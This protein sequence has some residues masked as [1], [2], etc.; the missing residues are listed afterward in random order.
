M[1]DIINLLI[2]LFAQLTLRECLLIIWMYFVNITLIGHYL[3]HKLLI[4]F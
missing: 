1:I 2:L 3:P 4:A